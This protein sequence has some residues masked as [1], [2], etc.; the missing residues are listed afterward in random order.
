MKNKSNNEVRIIDENYQKILDAI[1][2]V[3]SDSLED[4]DL[5]EYD[6]DSVK[7][8]FQKL[9]DYLKN[10]FL[11]GKTELPSD[12][13]QSQD[14]EDYQQEQ[15]KGLPNPIYQDEIE[16]AISDM[17]QKLLE[18]REQSQT[19][20][21]TQFDET[22]DE[23]NSENIKQALQSLIPKQDKKS[24]KEVDENY[25]NSENS[26]DLSDE[27]QNIED[28]PEE[29][30]KSP[31][32]GGENQSKK[33]ENS[34]YQEEIQKALGTLVNKE[35]SE[36]DKTQEDGQSSP[37]N[38]DGQANP[39][40]DDTVTATF[41]DSED[42]TKL[43]VDWT[44][45]DNSFRSRERSYREPD[46]KLEDKLLQ[47]F[48]KYLVKTNYYVKTYGLDKKNRKQIAKHFLLGLEHKII[49][50]TYSD[51][52]EPL[53]FYIDM[54]GQCDQLSEYNDFFR[55]LLNEKNIT[56]YFGYSGR[57]SK[58]LKVKKAGCNL[59]FD[60]CDMCH[61]FQNSDILPNG[62]EDSEYF[63][64][65]VFDEQIPL[66]HFIRNHRMSRL[67]AISDFD[68]AASIIRSSLLSKVYW[69]CTTNHYGDIDSSNYSLSDFKGEFIIA[70]NISQVMDYFEH[71]NDSGYEFKQ[72]K[73]QL[74]R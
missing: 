18:K 15:Y 53:S 51:V 46:E 17:V 71:I 6:Q 45:E 13:F 70:R 62:D 49:T 23:K 14:S 33:N 48:F 34:S 59:E 58:Y 30:G 40:E 39:N 41:N 66:E 35:L 55:R 27:P 19:G 37:D 28:E 74:R 36:Q 61:Y 29:Q 22:K 57:V 44:S 38:S 4:V 42:L 64:S 1:N 63:E 68:A 60:R 3:V 72:R 2:D 47:A 67:I 69:F 73:L 5:S 65:K 31:Q 21:D 32:Q 20:E 8:A 50:D 9:F 16:K 52:K 24:V 7:N 56:V 25:Q 43:N 12:D 26:S 54:K 11:K 10:K